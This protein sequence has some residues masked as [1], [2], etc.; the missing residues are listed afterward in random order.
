MI[1]EIILPQ[2]GDTMDEATITRWYKR[3]GDAVQ[4][5]TPLFEVLT[6]KA[7]I[8]VEATAA[9]YLRQVLAQEN[10]T[11]PTGQVIGYLTTS[12]DEPF[13]PSVTADIPATS[14]QTAGPA[15]P[16]LTHIN[17]G[18][19]SQ[20]ARRKPFVSPRAR[21][22]A[23][24]FGVDI[25]R[26]TPTSKTG[27]I[28]E[29]DVRNYL[30]QAKTTA[31]PALT[32]SPAPNLV[33]ADATVV[34]FSSIR[35][36]IAER[37][38]TSSR[39]VAR[40]TLTT[41]AD[42]TRL[43]ELRDEINARQTEIRSSFTDLFALLVSRALLKYPYMNATLHGE[44]VQQHAFVNLGVAADT[45]RGLLVPVV[46]DAHHKSL[47]EIYAD[48]RRL[49]EAARSGKISPD[50]LR[51]GTFTITNLGAQE[52]DAFTPIVNQP[53]IAILGIGRIVQKPAA[54]EGQ[55]ALRWLVTLSLSFDHRVVDGAPAGR[56]L[57]H[58]KHLVETP[59]LVLI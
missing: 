42:A 36:I 55:L 19:D 15:T 25:S 9:G 27:R 56:F 47:G 30:A 52:I 44:S 41:E 1:T 28:M 23:R 11:V 7:N 49:S 21:R 16:V 14:A 51:G 53:E 13:E 20:M 5:G 34:P 50:D 26:L 8:E 38:G 45:A 17:G 39:Q 3:Q 6:D 54:Y 32:A 18:S 29:A 57:Q 10:T 12:A 43:V 48:V 59:S 22:I 2:L 46:R 37:M 33:P 31:V 40:V 4:K 58:I 24:E 35:K